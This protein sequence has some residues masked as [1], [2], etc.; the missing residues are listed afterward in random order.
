MHTT[1]TIA[2]IHDLHE[3]ASRLDAESLHRFCGEWQHKERACQVHTIVLIAEVAQRNLHLDYGYMYLG[4][5]CQQ[6][7][8][9][10]EGEGWTRVHRAGYQCEFIGAEGKRCCQKTALQLDHIVAFSQGGS[11][12]LDNLMVLCGGHNR[13]KFER[14]VTPQTGQ[15]PP[16]C[17]AQNGSPGKSSSIRA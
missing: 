13:R 11:N 6:Y 7:L 1:I 16:A 15:F 14:E 9:L 5:Y 2:T 3:K 10:S 8:G 17:T 12:K 4:D